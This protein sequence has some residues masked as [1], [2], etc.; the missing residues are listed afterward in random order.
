[1][2]TSVAWRG[3]WPAAM[4]S[5]L[6]A[7][8][9]AQRPLPLDPLTPGERALADSIARADPRIRALIGGAGSRL[10]YVDFLAAKVPQR[11]PGAEEVPPR[12]S[13]D[14][15]FYLPDRDQGLRALVDLETRR[16]VEQVAVPGQSVPLS[17]AEVA[18][19]ARLALADQ[20]VTR[21]FAA[22]MPAFR[23]ATAPATREGVDSARI[24]GLRTVAASPSDPCW[25]RRCVVLFFRV[26]N[27]YL[28]MNRVIV[29]LTGQRVLIQAGER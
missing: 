16:V 24:E 25:R 28:Q 14:V 7:L 19:A 2:R 9:E 22:P 26:G 5:F 27:R 8:G 15:L 13:A 17:A 18:E 29:D 20:R 12:R 6:P 23:V 10:I 1:V 4:L 21:L 11:A 3:F